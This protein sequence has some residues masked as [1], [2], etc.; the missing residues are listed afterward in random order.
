MVRYPIPARIHGSNAA[1]STMWYS[2]PSPK[3]IVDAEH[4]PES[5]HFLL[6]L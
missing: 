1:P 5:G 3:A 4:E 6:L 2:A